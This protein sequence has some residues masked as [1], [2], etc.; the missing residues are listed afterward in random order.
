MTRTHYLAIAAALREA[1]DG[2]RTEEQRQGVTL[3]AFS[4]GRL[5]EKQSS[6][7]SLT[8]F[9]DNCDVPTSERT[10]RP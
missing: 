4:L 10:R 8:L 6:A 2:A 5:F 3:A 1:M 7:F 9:L